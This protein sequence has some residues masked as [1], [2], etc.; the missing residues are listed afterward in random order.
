VRA[1]VAQLDDDGGPPGADSWTAAQRYA[2][3]LQA[4]RIGEVVMRNLRS[5]AIFTLAAVLAA[6]C[7]SSS[8]AN[9]TVDSG[10]TAVD[11]PTVDA[12]QPAGGGGGDVPVIAD[13]SY[14]S[15]TSHVEVSGGKDLTAD[16]A[17]AVGASQTIEGTTL[18]LYQGGEGDN[19]IVFSVANASPD[20]PGIT[21]TTAVVIT[22]GDRNS[23]CTIEF[24]RNDG[25]G[26]AGT[27]D[28]V[29]LQGVGGYLGTVDVK[30]SFSAER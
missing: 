23:G 24:T 11:E 6:G 9:P 12:N 25:S 21:L 14:T 5:V 26:L 1:I 2:M 8:T 22:G 4:K 19:G 20:G 15:G 28:C 29:D 3:R 13:G 27:F 17:L 18:L 7:G 16:A 30:G 10:A